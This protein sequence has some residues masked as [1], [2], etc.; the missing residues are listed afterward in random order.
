MRAAWLDA[1]VDG[2]GQSKEFVKLD[3]ARGSVGPNLRLVDDLEC[4]FIGVS[5]ECVGDCEIE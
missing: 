1:D 3:Y 5:W 4:K 2:S